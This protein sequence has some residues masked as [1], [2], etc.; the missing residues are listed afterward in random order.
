VQQSPCFSLSLTIVKGRKEK[1]RARYLFDNNI[2]SK[3]TKKENN[4]SNELLLLPG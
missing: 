1:Y 2:K 3:L 4:I